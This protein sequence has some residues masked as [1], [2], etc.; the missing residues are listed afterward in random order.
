M[1]VLMLWFVI[2]HDALGKSCISVMG[3]YGTYGTRMTSQ[4]GGLGIGEGWYGK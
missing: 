4:P 1:S 3:G 2:G